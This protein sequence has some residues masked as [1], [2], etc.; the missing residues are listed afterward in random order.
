MW[1]AVLVSSASSNYS[2]ATV[3]QA[4]PRSFFQ[5]TV[6]SIWALAGLLFIYVA[7]LGQKQQN[8]QQYADSLD[9]QRQ[10]DLQQESIKRQN[11]ESSFFQLLNQQNAIVTEMRYGANS[12]WQGRECF[13]E[14]FTNELKTKIYN[15]R[16]TRATLTFSRNEK[17]PPEQ[18]NRMA[19]ESY[20]T[21]YRTHEASLGHYFRNLYHLIKFVDESDAL[22]SPDPK[23][24]YDNK[25]RYTS[26]VRA[27]LSAFE[28]A[29]LFYNGVS[30][31]GDKFKKLIHKYE[32]VEHLDEK[33]LLDISDAGLYGEPRIKLNAFK[34][35]PRI[36]TA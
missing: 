31:W 2:L 15:E 28:L 14:W 17:L 9:Q 34:A 22:K 13:Q 16:W 12:R 26:L 27:Q 20:E 8:L 21:L 3:Q 18:L 33:M 32:L 19:I 35:T 11:F 29:M 36:V 10:F 30:I 24:D 7:F 5:G 25:R 4:S 6:A 1:A 23:I